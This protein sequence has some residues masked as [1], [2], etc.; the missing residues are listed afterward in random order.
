M[1][2]GRRAEGGQRFLRQSKAKQSTAAHAGSSAAHSTHSTH[3]LCVHLPRPHPLSHRTAPDKLAASSL[4]IKQGGQVYCL[5][6]IEASVISAFTPGGPARSRRARAGQRERSVRASHS[7]LSVLSR[8]D[9]TRSQSSAPPTRPPPTRSHL[10]PLAGNSI[11]ET[12]CGCEYREAYALHSLA[13]PFQ[14]NFRRVRVAA[15]RQAK[16]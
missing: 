5:E 14:P 15:A 7:S 10:Q 4:F 13:Q 8:L 1:V 12:W 9:V 6:R 16:P 3:I 11:C 2:D